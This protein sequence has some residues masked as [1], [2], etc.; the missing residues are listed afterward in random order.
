MNLNNETEI[1]EDQLEEYALKL[2]G[3]LVSVAVDVDIIP[4]VSLEGPN[5]LLL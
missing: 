1:P 3:H 2:N 4:A 5:A